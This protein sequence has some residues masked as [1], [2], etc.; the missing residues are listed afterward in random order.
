MVFTGYGRPLPQAQISSHLPCL[1]HEI[2]FTVGPPLSGASW[3]CVKPAR[4]SRPTGRL[5]IKGSQGVIA[6]H[7]GCVPRGFKKSV[8]SDIHGLRKVVD[9]TNITR[10]QLETE[11]EALKEELLFMKK[12]H[13]EEVKGLEAQIARSG[14]TVEVDAPK[15]QDLSKIMAD[16]RA[17]YE[18]LAQ[19][20]REEL[21]KY[22]SQQIEESTTV[23]TTQ[24]AE[25]RD[26]E[27]TL[28]DLRRTFQALEID[29]EAMKN[30]KIS[31]ENS[32]RDVEA[33]YN[34][35]MEQLNGVLLHLESELAQTR[36]E[37]Q[38]QTQEYEALLNIK[39]KLEAEIATY[40]R[41]LEDGEDFRLND[42]LDSRTTSRKVVDGKVVSETNDT[43]VLRH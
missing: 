31:L 39:V 10:L 40:R 2:F 7:S 11:I 34:I 22:W 5:S 1:Q 25:I 17:Q 15:S 4:S 35:Q 36:A 37:G 38:R 30:Q 23:V 6:S 27:T 12:N 20:N 13:E 24:S 29:L 41:L 43:R 33:R 19:K 32:L 26:A 14:L 18:E 3:G 28:T 42:A 9:D 8:E 21:D 16:I